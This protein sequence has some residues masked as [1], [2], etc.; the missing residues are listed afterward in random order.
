MFAATP[1]RCYRP[2]GAS[3]KQRHST[4]GRARFRHSSSTTQNDADASTQPALRLVRLGLA[5]HLLGAGHATLGLELQRAVRRQRVLKLRSGHQPG[6]LTH[7]QSRCP[8]HTGGAHDMH[9]PHRRTLAWSTWGAASRAWPEA[10]ADTRYQNCGCQILMHGR[11]QQGGRAH[12]C[13]V[14]LGEVRPLGAPAAP[15]VPDLHDLQ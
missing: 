5:E 1:K 9:A 2:H 14:L 15:K 8:A 3:D 4:P 12:L 6:S 11:L 13:S 7:A 10:I